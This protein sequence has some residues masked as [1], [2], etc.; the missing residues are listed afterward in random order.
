[1]KAKLKRIDIKGFIIPQE[2]E[3]IYRWLDYPYTT[4]EMV[5]KALKEAD[6]DDVEVYINSYGGAV[7]IGS[8]IYTSLKDYKGNV[9]IKIVG[10]AASAA[11]VVAMAAKC[12][13]SPTAQMMLHNATTG[14]HG[15][16]RV[17]DKTSTMLQKINK[18]ILNAYKLKSGLSEE[19]LKAKMNEET[20]LTAEEALELGLI[21]EIMFEENSNQ[22]VPVLYNSLPMPSLKVIEELRECGSVENFKKK[23][24]ENRMNLNKN[25]ATNGSIDD[26]LEKKGKTKE[27]KD[28]MTLEEFK[29]K[30]PDIYD[31]VFNAGVKSERERIKAIEDLAIPGNEEIINEAKFESGITAE[32]VAIKIIKAEKERGAKFLENRKK[33]I[34][35]AKIEDVEGEGAPSKEEET[36]KEEEAIID[37]I[38]KGINMVRR[39]K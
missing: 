1:M 16:Y 36:K 34:A 23:V 33:D 7:H 12:I 27:V 20:W 5:N 13:M 19:E 26:N 38:E 29:E 10:Y 17:M 21:D 28:N 25:T 22:T 6:G 30:Y 8:E 3:W 37:K 35:E 39:N 15:D 14:A 24:V 31:E 18:S 2:D 9:L 11:S 4:A 32:E